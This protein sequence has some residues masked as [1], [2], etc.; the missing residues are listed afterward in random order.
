MEERESQARRTVNRYMWFAM[1]GGL[2][3]VPFLDVAAVS[4]L[5]LRMLQVLSN[6]YD[7]PFSR[8]V[9]KKIITALLGSIVPA[10]LTGTF[11]ATMNALGGTAVGSAMRMV[12]V[13]GQVIGTLTMPAFS[14]AATYAIGRVFI[15]HFESGGT[16]LDFDPAKLREYFREQFEKGRDL[17]SGTHAES[18][19][20]N[21]PSA[22]EA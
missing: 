7:V 3:P 9:G 20:G 2:L 17:A 11:G 22:T 1:G 14:G 12:P 13:V 10:S 5:Q 21:Q 19:H 18:G 4:A 16:L 8:D 15:Q 6:Q